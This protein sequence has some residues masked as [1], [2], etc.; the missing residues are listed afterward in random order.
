M[1]FMGWVIQEET[2]SK[3]GISKYK[4]LKG[5]GPWETKAG[6]EAFAELYLKT[7]PEANI[8]VC[9]D[10]RGERESARAA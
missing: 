4:K 3:K 2:K 9:Q 8:V 1:K 6:A 7:Y 5:A 10:V